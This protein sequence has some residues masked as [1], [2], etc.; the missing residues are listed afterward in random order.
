MI[1]GFTCGAFDLLH[2]GH[3]FMLAE[4]KKQCDRLIVGLHTNPTFDRPWKN[5]PVQT[6]Y[7]RFV[8]LSSCKHVDGVVPYDT[9]RDLVNIMS[10]LTIHK[11]FVGIEYYGT[12]IT[13]QDIAEEREIEIVYTERWHDYS[14]SELRGRFSK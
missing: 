14:S 9:E 13:G 1:I 3:I 7:E 2:P 12:Q 11:R 8:Q 5:S 6:T 10:T 4:C